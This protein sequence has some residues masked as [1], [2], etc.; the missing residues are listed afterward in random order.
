MFEDADP[1]L[2]RIREVAL[3]LP[4]TTEK[5]AHG[6]PTFR[7]PKMFG[8]YGGSIKGGERI[9]QCILFIPDDSERQALM[10]DSRFFVPAYVGPFGWLGLR[11]DNETDWTEV[12]ELLDASFRNVAPTE[13]VAELDAR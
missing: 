2:T 1:I 12:A 10:E 6:R 9:D 5:V 3:A 7:C 13:A 11:L 4:S 8:M